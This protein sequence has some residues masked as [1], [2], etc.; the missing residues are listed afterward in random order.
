MSIRNRT[1]LG[2][3][4]A[5]ASIGVAVTVPAYADNPTTTS[6]PKLDLVGVGGSGCPDGTADV[7][8]T[9][10]GTGFRAAYKSFEVRTPPEVETATCTLTFKTTV[11]PDERLVVR[12]ATYRGQAALGPGAQAEFK[13]RYSWRASGAHHDFVPFRH[14][15]ALTDSWESG[16]DVPDPRVSACGQDQ[17]LVNQTM[18]VSG[19]GTHRL[20]LTSTEF[21]PA[22]TEL[23]VVPCHAGD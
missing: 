16:H 12:K 18:K 10:D 20:T 14:A 22:A 7:T 15:G 8:I 23:A 21:G 2:G 6:P 9:P 19:S 17:L 1:L 11:A 13:V 5:I 4:L 3:A